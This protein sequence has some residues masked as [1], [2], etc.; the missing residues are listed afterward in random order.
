MTLLAGSALSAFAAQAQSTGPFPTQFELSS[1][2]PAN[3]GDGSNGFV[4]NGIDANDRNGISVS[5]A[6]DVNGDGVDDLIIG[7]STADPDGKSSAGESYVV[8]G[9]DF[10]SCTSDLNADGVADQGDT[11]TFIAAFLEGC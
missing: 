4:L 6:G 8:F 3:A 1:L 10:S 9:R 11:Q 5:S 2:L 7:A